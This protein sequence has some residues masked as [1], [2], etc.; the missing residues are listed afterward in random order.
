MASAVAVQAPARTGGIHA[1]DEIHVI[2]PRPQGVFAAIH[3]AWERRALIWWFGLKFAE[4]LWANTRLGWW[5]LPLRPLLSVVPRAI[6]FG[7]I[8][9]APSNGIPYLLFY[10][11]GLSAWDMFYRGWYIGTRCLQ[12]SSRYLKRMYLPRLIPLIASAA[13]GIVEYLLYTGFGVFVVLYYVIFK[14]Q[15][16]LKLGLNTLLLPASILLILGMAWSL[17]SWTSPFGV[18][19][20]DARWTVR[21]ILHFWNLL[22]PVIYP[23]SAV[24]AEF[25]TIAEINPMTAP[26]EMIREAVFDKGDITTTSLA[27]TIGTI[28]IVGSLGLVFFTRSETKALDD[29]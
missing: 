12:M 5:W 11:V 29:A 13:S 21:A 22:T 25:K 18:R 3:E 8:L 15:F 9:K 17:S 20:R 14:H 26:M 6:V 1:P 7:G 23:L 4:R 10:V 27:S 24:P 28:A 19:G 16:P 2:T